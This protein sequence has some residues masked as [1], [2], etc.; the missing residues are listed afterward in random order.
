MNRIKGFGCLAAVLLMLLT[1]AWA[2]DVSSRA[3]LLVQLPEDAQMIENVE[4]ENG[5]FIQ[6]YQL[7]GGAHVQLLRYA[8]FDMT[9]DELVQ[10]DWPGAEHVVP[11]DLTAV[12]GNNATGVRLT[13]AE[14][15]QEP[16]SVT[17]VLVTVGQ[18]TLVYQAVYPTSLGEEQI[19]SAVKKM[20]DTMDVLGGTGN[21]MMEVG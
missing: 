7:S 12:G 15:E 20:L 19:E 13:Y 10:S 16:V 18:D 6:T 14:A 11:L 8:S 9:L 21:A 4:F 1:C 17:L 5:D 2:E 3:V